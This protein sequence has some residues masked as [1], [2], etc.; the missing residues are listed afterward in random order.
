MV[1]CAPCACWGK[2]KETKS[3]LI[4]SQVI[5]GESQSGGEKGEDRTWQV[6]N[7]RNWEIPGKGW[8]CNETE[9]KKT[10]MPGGVGS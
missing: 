4:G 10:Q 1:W 6:F 5:R 9:T 2:E 8:N 3:I 7:V